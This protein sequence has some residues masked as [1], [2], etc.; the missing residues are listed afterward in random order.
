MVLQHCTFLVILRDIAHQYDHHNIIQLFQEAMA[1]FN[2]DDKE[3]LAGSA[4]SDYTTGGLSTD[5]SSVA[6]SDIAQISDL[7]DD[8]QEKYTGNKT[9]KSNIFLLL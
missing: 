5:H 2:D 9:C 8:F 6:D 7:E 3:L 1:G 4:K